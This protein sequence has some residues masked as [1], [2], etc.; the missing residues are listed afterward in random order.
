MIIMDRDPFLLIPRA[1]L[2][3]VTGGRI[4]N[5]PQ[6]LDPNLLQVMQQLSQ[7]VKE[8]GAQAVQ[9]KSAEGQNQMGMLQQV[10]QMKMGGGASHA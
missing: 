9:A 5:G 7:S 10:M 2:D 4:S 6:Q 8:V 3:F 1:V